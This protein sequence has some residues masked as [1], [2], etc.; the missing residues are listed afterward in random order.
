MPADW[1]GQGTTGYNF[2]NLLNGLFIDRQGWPRVREIYGTFAAQSDRFMPVLYDA[3]RTILSSS[4]SS[5]LYVLSNQLVRIASHHRWSRDFTRASLFRALREVV[6]CFPVYRT[7][8][9]PGSEEVSD[10]DRKR[11]NMAVR[12][13]KRR[14]PTMSITFFDFIGSLLLLDDP[15]GL[16]D[17]YRAERRRFVLKFQQVTGPITAKGLEDTAFYRYYP[18]ASVNEVGG[19]VLQPT[20]TVERFHDSMRDRLEHWPAEMSATGTHDTKRGEDMRA[21][22]NVI[23]E[24]PDVW[25]AAIAGWQLM[26]AAATSTIDDTRR[27]R[28]QRGIP[29]L[30]DSGRHLATVATR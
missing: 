27:P 4:L 29:D 1:P 8:I 18:L 3:K 21:R 28:R 14:N 17:E 9:R 25:R 15:D 12:I 2:L 6:A 19:D 22:L 16:S 7:Y 10:E 26:N 24:V 23:S 5:E 13:A 11:I 30:P 20:T